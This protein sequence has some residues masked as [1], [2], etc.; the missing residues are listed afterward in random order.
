MWI[1][2]NDIFN[3]P[4]NNGTI[5]GSGLIAYNKLKIYYNSLLANGWTPIVFTM[6]QCNAG[7]G[8]Q[9][10]ER[11]IFNNLIR[12]DLTPTYLIDAANQVELVDSTDLIYFNLDKIHLTKLAN[13]ILSTMLQNIIS[14][15]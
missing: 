10:S 4:N 9:E 14:V 12:N 5:L 3:G 8:A 15:I 13:L 7:L 1:G 6:T 2:T 11:V